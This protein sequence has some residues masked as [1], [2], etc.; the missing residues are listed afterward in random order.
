MHYKKFCRPTVREALRAVRDELG[1]DA[2]VL[3]TRMVSSGGLRGLMG[4]HLVVAALSRR[5]LQHLDLCRHGYRASAPAFMP[6]STLVPLPVCIL[7][8]MPGFTPSFMP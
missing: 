3:S 4:R 2:L 7:V 5:R 6:D 8:W 1:P